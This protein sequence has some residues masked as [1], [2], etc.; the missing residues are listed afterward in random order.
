M[1]NWS[2]ATG[3]RFAELGSN[4]V[5]NPS[6]TFNHTLRGGQRVKEFLGQVEG[7]DVAIMIFRDGKNQGKVATSVVPSANQLKNWGVGD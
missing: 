3:K 1:P 2:K 5:E 6:A 4:I 7:K